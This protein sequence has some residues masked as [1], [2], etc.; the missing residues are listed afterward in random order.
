MHRMSENL[1]NKK[2]KYSAEQ[3][4]KMTLI[5]RKTIKKTITNLGMEES[6]KET[7]EPKTRQLQQCDNFSISKQQSKK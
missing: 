3:I 4:A 7:T 6:N 2:I 5:E 1:I